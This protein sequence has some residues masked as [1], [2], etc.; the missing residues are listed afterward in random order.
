LADG[1]NGPALDELDAYLERLE[2]GA[3]VSFALRC[4]ACD[5]GWSAAIDV[6]EALWAELQ[7]AAER[8]LIEVDALARAYG[9][10]ERD[11]FHLSPTRRAAYLQLV[12]AS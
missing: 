6:G 4:P 1:L 10:T 9:W 12:G 11:V 7:H 8:F 5:H 2:P 3:I